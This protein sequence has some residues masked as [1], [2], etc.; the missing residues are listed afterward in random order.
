MPVISF[1]R[2]A[3]FFRNGSD[4]VTDFDTCVRGEEPEIVEIARLVARSVLESYYF[5]GSNFVQT[6]HRDWAIFRYVLKLWIGA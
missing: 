6:V 5:L 2:K 1:F 4:E 3:G